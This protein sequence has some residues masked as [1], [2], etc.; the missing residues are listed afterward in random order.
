M[1]NGTLKTS[2]LPEEIRKRKIIDDVEEN[3]NVGFEKLPVESNR[4]GLLVYRG[5]E[6]FVRFSKQQKVNI[7]CSEI[8]FSNSFFVFSTAMDGSCSEI[9]FY[10]W[11][12]YLFRFCYEWKIW[13]PGISNHWQCFLWQCWFVHTDFRIESNTMMS[14]LISGFAL[15]ILVAF[16]VFIYSWEKFL[17]RAA[18]RFFDS[19]GKST[20]NNFILAKLG[21]FS[22]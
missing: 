22:W 11:I 20:R 1:I 12:F 2:H 13:D 15:F 14:L 3:F 9:A 21:R 5:R 6:M 7:Y 18:E 19:I 10:L 17:R 8:R 16:G 4:I